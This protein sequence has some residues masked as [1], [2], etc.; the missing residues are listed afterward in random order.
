MLETIFWGTTKVGGTKNLG[1]LPSNV[2][3]LQQR[4]YVMSVSK[5]RPTFHN[6]QGKLTLFRHACYAVALRVCKVSFPQGLQV[7]S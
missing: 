7:L 4:D 3:V 6:V 5:C 2:P 1:A